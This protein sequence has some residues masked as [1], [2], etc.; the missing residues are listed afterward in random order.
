[1]VAFFAISTETARTAA[2]AAAAATATVTAGV[3]VVAA[4]KRYRG[5]FEQFE[6]FQ[7][8]GHTQNF[9]LP[10]PQ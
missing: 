8:V 5:G 9:V 1:L 4:E 10:Q 2:A 6:D 7:L 3:L